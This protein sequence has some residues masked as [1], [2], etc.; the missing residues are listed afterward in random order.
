SQDGDFMVDKEN[1]VD[2]VEVDMQNYYLNIDPQVEFPGC[3]S[4]SCWIMFIVDKKGRWNVIRL[5]FG[6]F[7]PYH[8]KSFTLIMSRVVEA[9]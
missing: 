7:E 2:E 8:E 1:M 3:S 5:E 9:I 6:E 4:H